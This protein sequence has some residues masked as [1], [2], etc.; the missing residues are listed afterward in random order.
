MNDVYKVVHFLLSPAQFKKV[1]QDQIA[2]LKQRD[3]TKAVADKSELTEQR[4][5]ALQQLA[6]PG[7]KE[8][9]EQ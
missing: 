5:K 2:W 6:W 3:A 8:D 4:I 9:K 1:K 7:K